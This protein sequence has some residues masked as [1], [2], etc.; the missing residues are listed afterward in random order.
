MSALLP[1]VNSQS[2]DDPFDTGRDFGESDGETAPI[3]GALDATAGQAQL[4]VEDEI[5]VAA[6]FALRI[7]DKGAGIESQ[8]GVGRFPSQGHLDRRR[9]R[10]LF[11]NGNILARL[12]IHDESPV[13]R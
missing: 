8:R 13:Y 7:Q 1:L 5:V 9:C 3:A 2:H 12:Q 11:A 10:T 6:H 4:V